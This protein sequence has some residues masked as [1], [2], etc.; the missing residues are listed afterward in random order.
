MPDRFRTHGAWNERANARYQRQ[1]KR[2]PYGS[3]GLGTAGAKVKTGTNWCPSF[4]SH[5]TA[6]PLHAK[7]LLKRRND[8]DQ[9]ALRRHH[10]IDVLVRRRDLVD[11]AFVLAA[12]DACGLER[13]IF[14]REGPARL[15]PAHAAARAVRAGTVQRRLAH[16]PHDDALAAHRART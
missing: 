1:R 13:Q 15:S 12:F 9:V 3:I 11:H 2:L 7:N 14:A 4:L 10:F 8:L 16:P 5:S 6:L